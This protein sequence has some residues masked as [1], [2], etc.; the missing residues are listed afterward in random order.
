MCTSIGDIFNSANKCE[1]GA[2][3]FAASA[4]C[5][6][7]RSANSS[8]S[9]QGICSTTLHVDCIELH[10]ELCTFASLHLIMQNLATF[11]AIEEH[12]E[13]RTDCILTCFPLICFY[14]V[15]PT[16][17]VG[18]QCFPKHG[19]AHYPHNK[20]YFRVGLY[21]FRACKIWPA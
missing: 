12:A 2:P 13:F 6:S 4:D 1:N 7:L 10:S 3:Y 5:P 8:F 18:L 16:F 21:V 9:C 14:A 19:Y 15:G 11:L 20:T 17:I